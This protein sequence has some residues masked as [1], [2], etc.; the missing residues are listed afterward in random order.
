MPPVRPIGRWIARRPAAE[1]VGDEW[2][3]KPRATPTRSVHVELI[4]GRSSFGVL[5]SSVGDAGGDAAGDTGR[6]A[7]G[8]TGADAAGDAGGDAAGDAGGDAGG[9]GAGV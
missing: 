1:S 9:D 6:D 3:S 2:G 5:D 4:D 7:A 8:D